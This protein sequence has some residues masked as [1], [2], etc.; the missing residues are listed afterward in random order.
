MSTGDDQ[1]KRSGRHAARRTPVRVRLRGRALAMAAVP[2]ALLMAAAYTPN[3]A[4]AESTAGKACPT[5]PVAV[6]DVS[7]IEETPVPK[8]ELPA[9]PP[10][11]SA[12][13]SVG[14]GA[15]S[16]PTQAPTAAPTPQPSAPVKTPAAAPTATATTTAPAVRSAASGGAGAVSAVYQGD[17]NGTAKAS[18]AGLI[19]D[20]LG[21]I[22]NLLNP[23]GSASPSPSASPT[24]TPAPATTAA[25]A[26]P[27]PRVGAPVQPGQPQP[28]TQPSAQVPGAGTVT[29]A[30]KPPAAGKAPTKPAPSASA[31][32]GASAAPS[33]S[34]APSASASAPS[35]SASPS[36]SGSPTVNPNC[37]VDARGLTAAAAPG[38][39]VV[40]EQNWTLQT[41]R[42][43]LHGA[44]FHGVYDVKTPTGTKRVLKFVV[45]SVDI[46]NLDMS[47][48]E[49]NG[50][51]FH[52]QGAPGSTSTMRDGQVTMYVE[53]LSG[54]LSK[55]LGLPIP[56]DL[57]EITLTPDTLPRW[58][59]DL[60]GSVP[61][62]LDLELTGVTAKQA[63]QFGGTLHIPGM[64]M[65]ND[66]APYSDK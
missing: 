62:P 18:Q 32:S 26:A 54:H 63:G 12:T 1:P 55:V 21:G 44:A 24:A 66:N 15:T 39:Q 13:P 20:I 30:P 45:S 50:V 59:Y 48:L 23:G 33:G 14:A 19:D 31:S 10:G 64:H 60:I 41:S 61:I 43:G 29:Q 35:A 3:P 5:A 8:S 7:P 27:A 58:L 42:L 9:P 17:A 2:T 4:S 34:A 38:E 22:N 52:V 65:F 46:E 6:P 25:P 49:G 53:R 16:V 47:T 36:A 11:P 37:A 51:T 56:I 40:P 57:G 28:P